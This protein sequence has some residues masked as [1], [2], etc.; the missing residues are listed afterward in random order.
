MTL[1][2]WPGV[3]CSAPRVSVMRKSLQERL[4]TSH[5]LSSHRWLLSRMSE[6]FPVHL[7][8]IISHREKILIGREDCM[9]NVGWPVMHFL[10]FLFPFFIHGRF[11]AEI[12]YLSIL[13]YI[14]QSMIHIVIQN[15]EINS[16]SFIQMSYR[17]YSAPYS[18]N[19]SVA[20]FVCHKCYGNVF[21]FSFL[22]PPT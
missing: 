11:S 4:F 9:L 8:K 16:Q 14:V 15:R 12:A 5:A 6:R 13:Y 10:P 21:F 22:S 3:P 7:I 20:I 19:N 17:N 2:A 1:S 18:I